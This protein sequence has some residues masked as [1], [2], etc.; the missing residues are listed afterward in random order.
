MSELA[1]LH[2]F[3]LEGRWRFQRQLGY[4]A[5][6]TVY[7]AIDEQTKLPVAIKVYDSLLGRTSAKVLEKIAEEAELA[8]G[9]ESPY[10]V[11]VHHWGIAKSEEGLD[12]GYI[13]MEYLE[14][15]PLRD[16][17]ER[18]VTPMPPADVVDV[19]RGV[20]SAVA[21]LHDQGYVHRDLKPENVFLLHPHAVIDGVA[22]KLFDLG[23]V[24]AVSRAHIGA[25]RGTPIYVAPEVA[26]R[27]A[28]IGRQ[29]DV[30]STGIM[31]YE[32]LV[33]RP[34]VSHDAT[35]A[36]I[37]AQHVYGELDPLPHHLDNLP[38]GEVY[39]RATARDPSRRYRDASEFAR[40]LAQLLPVDRKRLPSRSPFSSPTIDDSVEGEMQRVSPAA[41]PGGF[42]R[43]SS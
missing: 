28:R 27:A 24:R 42:T 23:A 5:D 3:V 14:G 30:Y 6:G 4:G 21:S 35:P 22:V 18:R 36:Q 40:E 10:L 15:E 34:P 32:M 17:L 8:A 11:D 7:F 13:V 37:V 9:I 1:P 39:R 2:R 31:L 12:A 25:A 16:V 29:S 33:G 20:L 19:L 26:Q 43:D 38:V 41:L